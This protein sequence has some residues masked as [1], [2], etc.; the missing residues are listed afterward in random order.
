MTVAVDVA[1][2]DLATDGVT[3]V[4]NLTGED[5]AMALMSPSDLRV[6]FVD[7]DGVATELTYTIDFSIAG[8]YRN[9]AG[10]LTTLAVA[11]YEDG[12]RLAI[13]RNTPRTQPEA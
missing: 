9:G 8:D 10:T 3:K 13:R 12:G 7:A 4:F 5:G 1:E 6:W 2:L 11:A